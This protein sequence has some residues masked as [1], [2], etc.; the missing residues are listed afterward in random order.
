M[1]S[2]GNVTVGTRM[3]AFGKS[4]RHLKENGERKQ[5]DSFTLPSQLTCSRPEVLEL[6]QVDRQA[7][8]LSWRCLMRRASQESSHNVQPLRT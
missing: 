6:P 8:G 2:S 5:G 7:A 4:G 3:S 1:E